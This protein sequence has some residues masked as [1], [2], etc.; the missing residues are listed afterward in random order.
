MSRDNRP[1]ASPGDHPAGAVWPGHDAQSAHQIPGAGWKQ[2]AGRVWRSIGEDNVMLMAAGLAFY[3]MLALFPTLIAAITIYGLVADPAQVQ[4]LVGTISTTMSGGG[5]VVRDQL[6]QIVSTSSKTLSWGLVISL[7]AALW[8]ASAG[9][10][11]LINTVNLAYDEQE[12][13]SFVRRRAL[14]M[15]LTVGGILFVLVAVALIAVLPAVLDRLGLD[16]T[17]SRLVDLLRWP[18]LLAMGMTALGVIYK[19]GPD[20]RPPR[21]R[22]VTW[23]S[24]VAM[25]LWIAASWGFSTYVENFASYNETYGSLGGVVVLLMWFYLTG[26]A[27]LLGAEINSEI[28]LQTGVDTTVGEPRPRGQRGA[29]KADYT[30]LDQPPRDR[31]RRRLRGRG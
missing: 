22:W 4:D 3:S 19:I 28:E 15:V 13:R 10:A 14:A 17:G 31:L 9:A 23:G 6:N 24:V 26:F 7:V 27:I 8:S 29:V 2:I 12:T 11:N 1:L 5:E 16:D 30:P 18:L 20:R 21:A 25:A